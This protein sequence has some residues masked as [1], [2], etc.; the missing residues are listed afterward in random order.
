MQQLFRDLPEAIANTAELSARLTYQMSDLGYRF[1][2]YPVP[3]RRDD[4]VVS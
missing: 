4:A 3:G 2:D 1:P